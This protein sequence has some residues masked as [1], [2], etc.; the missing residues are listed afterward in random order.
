M[1]FSDGELSRASS[2]T[3]FPLDSFDQITVLL[4][5]RNIVFVVVTATHALPNALMVRDVLKQNPAA[6]K[7]TRSG[8]LSL[9]EQDHFNSNGQ[10]LTAAAAIVDRTVLTFIGLV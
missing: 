9:S 8:N 2:I 7:M 1:F 3:L 10:R 5:Q 6:L 4:R